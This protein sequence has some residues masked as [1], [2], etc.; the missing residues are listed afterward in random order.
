ME[1][2]D[3][4]LRLCAVLL[5]CNI[6]FIWG[7]S[8]MNAEV[9]GAISGFVKDILNRIFGWFSS[10]GED[11]L[12]GDGVLRKIAHFLEFTS[13]GALLRWLFGML[14]KKDWYALA[15]G[16]MIAC[17][18]ETIQMFVP[19]RGPGIKDVGIDTCGVLFGMFLLYLGH[20][21]YVRKKRKSLEDEE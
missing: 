18:D 11:M 16:T 3:K 15:C 21:Y 8:L 20:T 1:R 19:E 12:S 9:S 14:Q 10:S 4:R 13:L 6:A 5:I 2:T 17:I 7:N